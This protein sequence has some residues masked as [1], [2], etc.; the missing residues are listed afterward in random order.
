MFDDA[1]GQLLQE[2]T[3]WYA[4]SESWQGRGWADVNNN[5]DYLDELH[6][7]SLIEIEGGISAIGNSSFTAHYAMKNKV[8]GKLAATMSA[9]LIYFNLETRKSMPLTEEIKQQMQQRWRER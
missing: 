8:T 4:K 5:I 3:G 9:K 6:A 7:G 2:A 1:C